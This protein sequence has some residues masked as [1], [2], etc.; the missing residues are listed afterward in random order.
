MPLF[1]VFGFKARP[2]SM[3]VVSSRQ[4]SITETMLE[5]GAEEVLAPFAPPEFGGSEKRTERE[6]DNLLL[7]APPE[8]KFLT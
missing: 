7:R 3:Y 1:S 4:S 5:R 2:V 6:A 8:I